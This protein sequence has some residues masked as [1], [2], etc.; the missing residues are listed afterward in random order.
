MFNHCY[1]LRWIY[2]DE[3]WDISRLDDQEPEEE[4]RQWN[5]GMFLNCNKLIG[6]L[7]TRYENSHCN[8]AFAHIDGG[9]DCP[10]YFCTEQQMVDGINSPITTIN[11]HKSYSLDGRPVHS[12]WLKR[13]VLIQ[14]G[15]K[16]VRSF[17]V[18]FGKKNV[19]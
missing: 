15:R 1:E 3:D 12:A 5:H 16:R 10:G 4:I 18:V 8:S 6:G 11:R 2:V 19:Y 17:T 13:G 7:G 14:D 9:A